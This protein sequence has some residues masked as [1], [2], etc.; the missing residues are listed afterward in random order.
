MFR[1]YFHFS[2]VEFY[3]VSQL[4]YYPPSTAPSLHFNRYHFR[5]QM[6]HWSESDCAL[7]ST[8]NITILYC[9]LYFILHCTFSFPFLYCTL[10]YNEVYCFYSPCYTTLHCTISIALH[11]KLRRVTLM[12][13]D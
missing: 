9:V 5:K 11:C 13:G 3:L 12:A 2:T 6:G 7:Y 8:L 10:H 4:P 1:C